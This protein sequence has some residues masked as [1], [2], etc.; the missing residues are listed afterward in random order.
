M[1]ATTIYSKILRFRFSFNGLLNKQTCTDIATWHYG[2]TLIA[3]SGGYLDGLTVYSNAPEPT[4]V[5][6]RVFD[7]FDTE[8]VAMNIVAGPGSV[9]VNASSTLT[10][11]QPFG[12][13]Y[14]NAETSLSTSYSDGLY[15][16][17]YSHS[18]PEAKTTLDRNE[19][20]MKLKINKNYTLSTSQLQCNKVYIVDVE[21]L[22]KVCLII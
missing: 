11:Y 12:S 4:Y 2:N 19:A 21:Q 8:A 22:I 18:E 20:D 6:M 14:I 17:V 16:L 1:N 13:S 9:T 10:A 5:G 15:S 7:P 3:T